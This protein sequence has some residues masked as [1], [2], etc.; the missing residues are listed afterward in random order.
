LANP[1]KEAAP[2]ADNAGEEP[3]SDL[4]FWSTQSTP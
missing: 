3:A 1:P 2:V 4:P